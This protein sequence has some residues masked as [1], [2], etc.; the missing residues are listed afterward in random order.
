MVPARPLRWIRLGHFL[1]L[2]SLY[3]QSGKL[4]APRC[5]RLALS[6][7]APAS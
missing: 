5:Y 3:L 4:K 1:C 7:A 6:V 2:S